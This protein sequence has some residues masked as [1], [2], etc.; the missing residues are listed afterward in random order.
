MVNL[1]AK[2]EFLR[3]LG[4]DSQHSM[5]TALEHFLGTYELLRFWQEPDHV[6]DAGLFHSVYGRKSIDRDWLSTD[7]RQ[8][9]R[10]I[11]GKDAESLVYAFCSMSDVKTDEG[12]VIYINRFDGKE[13]TLDPCDST[14][15]ATVAF[16]NFLEQY[17]RLGREYFDGKSMPWFGM[18]SGRFS[19]RAKLAFRASG[20][21]NQ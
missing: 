11:I 1:E 20:L 17:V 14:S 4:A 10:K 13:T 2:L 5:G 21:P 3:T 12:R 9:V 19:P 16:A 8:F 18:H 6:C 7:H 15:L